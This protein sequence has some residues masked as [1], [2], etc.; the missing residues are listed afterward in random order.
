MTLTLAKV[1]AALPD[2]LV[3]NTLYAVRA[4]TGFDLYFTDALGQTPHALNPSGPSAAAVKGTATVAVPAG[5]GTT[6]HRE[7]VAAP[8]VVPANLILLALA[9]H[10]DTA[11]NHEEMLDVCSLSAVAG[12]NQITISIGFLSPTSGPVLVNWSAI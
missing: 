11:E 7:T 12:T 8:G 3:A 5:R 6:F 2:P 10:P 9:P 4:G 1:V